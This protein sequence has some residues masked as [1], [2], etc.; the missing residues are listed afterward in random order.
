MGQHWTGR[1]PPQARG[2]PLAPL[3]PQ[4]RRDP[5]GAGGAAA[6]PAHPPKMPVRHGAGPPPGAAGPAPSAAGRPPRGARGRAGPDPPAGAAG[7]GRDMTQHGRAGGVSAAILPC[8]WQ[9]R[10]PT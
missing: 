5:P 7:P 10:A 9:R 2:A 4:E 8:L 3:P 6:P 1:G